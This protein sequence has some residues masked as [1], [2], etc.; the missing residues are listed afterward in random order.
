MWINSRQLT[1]TPSSVD[2]YRGGAIELSILSRHYGRQIDAY[3]IQTKRCDRYGQDEGYSERVMLIYDGLHYDAMAVSAFEG[4]PEDLDITVLQVHRVKAYH[5][6]R[7]FMFAALPCS[8]N[9]FHKAAS[10]VM[11]VHCDGSAMEI[12]SST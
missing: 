5:S 12:V 9:G 1:A 4:A 7:K 3:D 11:A 6:L 10:T 8:C 2:A